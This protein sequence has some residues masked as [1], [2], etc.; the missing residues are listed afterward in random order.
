MKNRFYKEVTDYWNGKCSDTASALLNVE[1]IEK[2][3]EIDFANS[4]FTAVGETDFSPQ[5]R[6]FVRALHVHM[7]ASL[8]SFM[9]NYL[10]SKRN[11]E[12]ET[13]RRMHADDADDESRR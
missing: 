3:G 6:L 8:V 10:E 9:N 7:W 5:G 2:N 1:I 11:I 13:L 12:N 4:R